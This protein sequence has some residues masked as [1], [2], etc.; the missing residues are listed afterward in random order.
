MSQE[1]RV[2][3][4]DGERAAIREMV[5]SAKVRGE[6]I[7]GPDGLLKLLT[8]TV[9]ETALDEE[10]IDYLGYEK[11]AVE[12]RNG[13][14]SRNGKRTKTVISDAVGPVEIEV[15]RDRD[16]RFR[17][18]VVEKRPGATAGSTAGRRLTSTQNTSRGRR[19]TYSPEETS[20]VLASFI[21]FDKSFR[22]ASASAWDHPI[23]SKN[24]GSGQ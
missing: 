24:L 15:P 13:A 8:K 4:G 23:V 7:A 9:I 14:N 10:M 20:K 16:S 18:Q 3:P 21:P 5:K 17:P 2:K 22:N 11:H 6:D 1:T 12:G 19:H